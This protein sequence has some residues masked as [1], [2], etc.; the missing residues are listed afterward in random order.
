MEMHGTTTGMQELENW[1]KMMQIMKTTMYGT[2][3]I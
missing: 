2:S 3:D 1:G